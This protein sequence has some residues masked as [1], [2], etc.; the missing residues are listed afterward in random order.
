M[1]VAESH[2]RGKRGG[3]V[4]HASD[5]WLREVGDVDPG[6]VGKALTRLVK[7]YGYIRV[8]LAL[9][10]YLAMTTDRHKNI[11]FFARDFHQWERSVS[12]PLVDEYGEFTPKGQR[13]WNDINRG[14]R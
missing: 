9:K 12:E 10:E 5:L 1:S 13:I 6:R 8:W 11:E 4:G 7:A 14:S 2:I 3:W